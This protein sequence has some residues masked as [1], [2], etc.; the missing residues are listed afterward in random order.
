MQLTSGD[1]RLWVNGT[2][3]GPSS[4]T[5]GFLRPYGSVGNFTGDIAEVLVYDAPL[6]VPTDRRSRLI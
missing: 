4:S 2:L 5:E 6:A 3:T 1:Y